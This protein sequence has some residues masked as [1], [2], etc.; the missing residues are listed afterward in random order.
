MKIEAN[1]SG[2]TGSQIVFHFDPCHAS[3]NYLIDVFLSLYKQYMV[4]GEMPKNLII[5]IPPEKTFDESFRDMESKKKR[6]RPW[7]FE[8][9]AL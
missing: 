5:P 3:E 1:K 9:A 7:E 8:N 2:T 6:L 4:D